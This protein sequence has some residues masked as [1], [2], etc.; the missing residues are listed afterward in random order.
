M[1]ALVAGWRRIAGRDRRRAEAD[2]APGRHDFWGDE[3]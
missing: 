1:P 2:R 3:E